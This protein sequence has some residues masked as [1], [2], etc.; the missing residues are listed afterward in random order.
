[1]QCQMLIRDL[2]TVRGI[3]KGTLKYLPASSE[4]GAEVVS[5]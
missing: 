4:T 2:D 3:L 1:M 5:P